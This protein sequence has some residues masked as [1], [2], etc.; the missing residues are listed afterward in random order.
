L[1]PNACVDR[2]L[3]KL[4]AYIH[5]GNVK[6]CEENPMAKKGQCAV[7]A[8][9]MLLLLPGISLGLTDN[10]EGLRD[11]KGVF[12]N[13]SVSPE[14]QKLGLTENQIKTDVE[15]KLRKFGVRILTEKPPEPKLEEFNKT[16]Q[17]SHLIVSLIAL[18]RQNICFF[19]VITEVRE[20]VFRGNGFAADGSI[21]RNG[22][23]GITDTDNMRKIRNAVNDLIEKFINDYLAANPRR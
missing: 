5:C 21:W 8:L 4:T 22:G 7:L 10:Q 2:V 9:V 18:V 12:V 11:I 20:T 6:L 1:V 19:S 23:I 13:V 14:L 16:P 17:P 15:L 3:K